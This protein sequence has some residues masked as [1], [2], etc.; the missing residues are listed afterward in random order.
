MPKA[1]E[2]EKTPATIGQIDINLDVEFDPMLKLKLQRNARKRSA[3][4]TN[5]RSPRPNDDLI[6][7]PR[8]NDDSRFNNNEEDIYFVKGAYLLHYYI[9]FLATPS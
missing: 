5:A 7:K 4:A 2:R 6:R 9:K 1:S 3:S 8:L